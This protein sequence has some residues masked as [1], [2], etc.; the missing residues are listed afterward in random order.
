MDQFI[1][2]QFQKMIETTMLVGE[3]AA[4]TIHEAAQCLSGSLLNGSKVLT[5]GDER[6]NPLAQLANHYLF[7]GL[8]FERPGFPALNLNQLTAMS[9][10][11]DRFSEAIQLHGQSGDCLLV[12]SSGSDDLAL[13]SAMEAAS[14]AQ[15]GMVFLGNSN[16]RIL[17]ENLG[18]NDVKVDFGELTD[19]LLAQAQLQAVHCICAAIDKIVFGAE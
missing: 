6:S 19:S 13:L 2:N 3:Q 15:L 10:H 9:G 12:I 5:L 1:F 14:S 16:A 11:T 4:D 7:N 18:Y 8:D 17:A